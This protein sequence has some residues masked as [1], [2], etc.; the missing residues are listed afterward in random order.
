MVDPGDDVESAEPDDARSDFPIVLRDYLV[1][2]SHVFSVQ[3][4]EPIDEGFDG[5]DHHHEC[6]TLRDWW[7]K[8]RIQ[9]FF[10]TFFGATKDIKQQAIAE[11][12]QVSPSA[13][14]QWKNKSSFIRPE[15]VEILR[16]QFA[17][18]IKGAKQPSRH[19]LDFA[20]Y[21][22]AIQRVYARVQEVAVA[23]PEIDPLTFWRLWFTFRSYT[24]IYAKTDDQRNVAV[25]EINKQVHEIQATAPSAVKFHYMDA[26]VDDMRH[27]IAR[28]GWVFAKVVD[29]LDEVCW[30]SPYA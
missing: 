16:R 11:C 19:E 13:V 30:T 20:G 27:I 3:D 5:A 21:C 9:L 28:W 29:R 24:W 7:Y 2:S 12:L 17:I 14:T 26:T 18:L 1:T 23:P 10:L 6:K 4:D 8:G 25:S 15:N 22:S